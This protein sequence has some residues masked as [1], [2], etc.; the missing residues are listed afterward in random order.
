[1]LQ[2]GLSDI[3][4]RSVLPM[5]IACFEKM[6]VQLLHKV[7]NCFFV[8]LSMSTSFNITSL[9]QLISEGEMITLES[10]IGHGNCLVLLVLFLS[11]GLYGFIAVLFYLV[12][13]FKLLI[14]CILSFKL[15]LVI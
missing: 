4:T 2:L 10:F 5:P 1:M 3:C 13:V 8:S 14:F 11:G 6:S 12:V 9:W 7:S 15:C